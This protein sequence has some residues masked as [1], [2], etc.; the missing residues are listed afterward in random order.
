MDKK[1]LS[2]ALADNNLHSD[3]VDENEL[4]SFEAVHYKE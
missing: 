4:I 3:F 1:Y 2:T